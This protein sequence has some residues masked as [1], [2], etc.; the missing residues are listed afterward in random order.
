MLREA[1]LVHGHL[2][3]NCVVCGGCISYQE[4]FLPHSIYR[5]DLMVGGAQKAALEIKFNYNN[6]RC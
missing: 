4:A 3:S 6:W 5:L 1:V 2:S